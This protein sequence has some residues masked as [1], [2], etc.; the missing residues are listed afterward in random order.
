MA[1]RKDRSI[2]HAFRKRRTGAAGCRHK[3]VLFISIRESVLDTF[4]TVVNHFNIKR[5]ENNQIA[6]GHITIH[7]SESSTTI[8]FD[9]DEELQQISL[10]QAI[11]NFVK[12]YNIA[13]TIQKYST[14]YEIFITKGTL[15]EITEYYYHC[16]LLEYLKSRLDFKVDIGWGLG[17]DVRT[18]RQNAQYAN[19]ESERRGGDCTFV[20]TEQNDI[21]GPLQGKNR[22]IYHNL[23]DPIVNDIGKKTKLSPLT[24]QKLI[25]VIEKLN[26][27]ELSAGDIAYYLGITERSANRILNKLEATGKAALLYTKSEKLRGRPKKIYSLDLPVSTSKGF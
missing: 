6:I 13:N 11:M 10:Q 8:N 4:N 22:M 20:I 18:A 14:R 2:D 19:I 21:I 3:S 9:Y 15:N 5:L 24:I 26:K 17:A 27:R 25:A 23:N 12:D 7:H 16:A 1:R